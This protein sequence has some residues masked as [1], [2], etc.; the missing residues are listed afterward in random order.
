METKLKKRPRMRENQA[1]AAGELKEA[2][3]REER[4]KG[5]GAGVGAGAVCGDFVLAFDRFLFAISRNCIA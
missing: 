5:I 4:R 3:S 1:P 2:P